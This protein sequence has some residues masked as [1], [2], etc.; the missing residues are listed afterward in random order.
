ML[1]FCRFVLGI[2]LLYFFISFQSDSC[3]ALTLDNPMVD[4]YGFCCDRSAPGGSL[5]PAHR[6]DG[7]RK[8]AVA[9]HMAQTLVA[10]YAAVPY[11]NSSCLAAV[12]KMFSQL[13]TFEPMLGRSVE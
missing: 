8:S 1:S 4:P 7:T 3:L 9:C 6:F 13:H 2:D 10:S 5:G 11:L 12:S